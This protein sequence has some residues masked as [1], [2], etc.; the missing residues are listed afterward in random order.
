VHTPSDFNKWLD[1]RVAQA[2]LGAQEA[3]AVNPA[4]LSDKA[5]LAPYG[6]DLDID[7]RLL[8]HLGDE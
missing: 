1:S 2:D 6:D 7:P 5:Y 8:A 4:D 3:I